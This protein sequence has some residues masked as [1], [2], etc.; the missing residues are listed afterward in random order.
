MTAPAGRKKLLLVGVIVAVVALGGASVA[1]ALTR[2]SRSSGSRGLATTGGS[3]ASGPTT[4]AEPMS[5]LVQPP[6]GSSN[7]DPATIVS[8]TA[9]KGRINTV[10][11]TAAD[12]SSVEGTVSPGGSAWRSSGTLAL[13]TDYTVT[14][15]GQLPNGKF[16]EQV[17]HFQSVVPS[18]NLG[19]TITPSSGLT[20]GIGEPIVLHFDHS[21]TN[22]DALIA[23]I[24]VTESN[25]VSSGWHWF[26][27]KELHFRPQAY[28]PTGEKVSLKANLTGFNAGNGVWGTADAST[29][30]TVGDAHVSTAN[31]TTDQM[32]VT[33]NGAVVATYPISAGR[34][35]YPTMNGIHI[36]L[37]RQQDVH[38][39]S[40]TV[41]IPVNSPDGYDEHVYWDVNISDGGEFV[42]AAPW[43][44]GAQGNSNVSH[45]CVNLSPANAESFYNFSHIGDIIEVT[46]SPRGPDLGD[47]G[48]MDWNLP[49]SNWTPA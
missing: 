36:D 23:A 40:S 37:Y 43:S 38:M 47:H 6:D 12:G 9:L 45:G 35:Q 13:K 7:V 14:I 10:T 28:W 44:T 49:W 41:G 2:S 19:V 1:F 11:V 17:S 26:N 34:T 24:Q 21:V 46:G 8:V 29:S 5:V 22:K 39:V 3:R 30:F 32:T 16:A 20:V 42:H 4:T 27:S 15:N 48:T 31:V 25:P 18:A 33:S